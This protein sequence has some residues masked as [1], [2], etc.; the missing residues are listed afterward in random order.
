ML[1]HTAKIISLLAQPLLMPIYSMLYVLYANTPWSFLPAS[2]KAHVMLYAGIGTSLL[3]LIV[4][5]FFV[6]L[7]HVSDIELSNPRE[8]KIPLIISLIITALTVFFSR[9]FIELPL[10]ILGIILG[11]MLMLICAIFVT[12]FWKISMHGMGTGG[13][14]IFVILI[15]YISRI[16][17]S[18]F[19]TISIAVSGF[20]GWA[21]LYLRAHS[22]SQVLV[23][24][25]VGI[26]LMWIG[27]YVIA[28]NL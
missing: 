8:R 10:P 13:C 5:I 18:G 24:Y 22:P 2:Y 17:F 27:I 28:A 14:T 12:P 16:D 19:A 21:R 11:E 3:P 15:G 23:G 6:A 25:V 7:K 26:L 9:N 20:V 4:L 1:R